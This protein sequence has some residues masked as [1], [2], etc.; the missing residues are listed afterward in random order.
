MV[1]MMCEN[2]ARLFGMS[3]RKGR[4]APGL[5]ADIVILDTT[6]QHTLN[7]SELLSEAGYTPYEGMKAACRVREVFLRGNLVAAHGRFCGADGAGE[8]VRA[9]QH[10]PR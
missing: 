4:I 6:A 8:F 9:S 2:P 10:L 5:D 7:G 3:H 1:K